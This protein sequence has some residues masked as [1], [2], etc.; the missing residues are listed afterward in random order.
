MRAAPERDG[1]PEDIWRTRRGKSSGPPGVGSAHTS[2]SSEVG[3]DLVDAPGPGG[4]RG[5]REPHS[6]TSIHTAAFYVF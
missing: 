5:V 4:V 3:G 2:S 6:W 1:T